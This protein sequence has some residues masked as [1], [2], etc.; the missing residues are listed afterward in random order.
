MD[1]DKRLKLYEEKLSNYIKRFEGLFSLKG[2]S[3]N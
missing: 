1:N 2:L 3:R